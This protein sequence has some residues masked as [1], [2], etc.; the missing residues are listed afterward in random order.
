M[1]VR[2]DCISRRTPSRGTGSRSSSTGGTWQPATGKRHSSASAG[3]CR[4]TRIQTTIRSS[5][6][7]CVRVEM[8]F[9]PRASPRAGERSHCHQS[10]AF[11]PL[12]PAA[13]MDRGTLNA[14]RLPFL[15]RS[16]TY[17]AENPPPSAGRAV[18]AE[19]LSRKTRETRE[20][21]R[22]RTTSGLCA[23]GR[24]IARARSPPRYYL[25]LP[26]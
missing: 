10:L 3:M 4:R 18:D 20:H 6:R 22:A 5:R 14:R 19:R 1:T 13:N 16:Q 24:I 11:S 9:Q 2:G 25:S 8:R 12:S 15:R 21:A 26:E 7:R 17:E 23:H